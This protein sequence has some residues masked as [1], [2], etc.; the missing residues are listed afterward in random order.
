MSKDLA[1]GKRFRLRS[2]SLDQKAYPIIRYIV[3]LQFVDVTTQLNQLVH[4]FQLDTIAPFMYNE[5]LDLFIAKFCQLNGAKWSFLRYAVKK[6]YDTYYRVNRA[7]P[8]PPEE[9]ED[10][11]W[12]DV[13][14]NY[15]D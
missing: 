5:E 9:G 3:D 15:D 10:R 4:F 13:G 14:D 6:L 8:D 7:R 12:V 2:P 1:T 11:E